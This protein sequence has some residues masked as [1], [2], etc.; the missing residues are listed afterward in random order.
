[1]WSRRRRQG[2]ALHARSTTA[3]SSQQAEAGALWGEGVV[4]VRSDGRVPART[5]P[6]PQT[7]LDSQPRSAIHP[8]HSVGRVS[9][10]MRPGHDHR[11]GATGVRVPSRLTQS[12]LQ[13]DVRAQACLRDCR[14]HQATP[15]AR[16]SVLAPW[17]SCF[18][19]LS[20]RLLRVHVPTTRQPRPV[21]AVAT[22][23]DLETADDLWSVGA[24]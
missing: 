7:L 24:A 4:A 1:M 5:L 22:L 19:Q 3:L 16:V 17:P 10:P 8:R 14:L 13:A 15:K 20:R 12:M 11:C 21:W 9:P 23:L 6:V 2:P 18:V